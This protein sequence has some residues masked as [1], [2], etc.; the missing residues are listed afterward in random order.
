MWSLDR[1]SPPK[2]VAATAYDPIFSRKGELFFVKSEGKVAYV[3][4]M[5]VDGTEERKAIPNYCTSP[6]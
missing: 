1:R 2:I 5:S 4:L 6:V 3:F